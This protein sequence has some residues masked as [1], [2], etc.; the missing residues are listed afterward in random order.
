MKVYHFSQN[1][2]IFTKILA[3]DFT[4]VVWW[5][6]LRAPNDA[7]PN[8]ERGSNYNMI[9]PKHP[10]IIFSHRVRSL[11][12]IFS[13]MKISIMIMQST[14]VIFVIIRYHKK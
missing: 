9:I 2:I 5:Y 6:L 3:P 11:A 8:F 10:W 7:T 14:A 13:K 12:D 4:N 1:Q